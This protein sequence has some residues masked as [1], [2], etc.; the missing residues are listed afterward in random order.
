MPLL[1]IKKR[2]D[3]LLARRKSNNL[4]GRYLIFQKLKRQNNTT[5]ILFGFT[6]TKKVGIAVIRNKIKR[7]LRS[8]IRFL[9]KYEKNYF[10]NGYNYILIGKPRIKNAKFCEIK[11]EIICFLTRFKENEQ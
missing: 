3:F 7:R 8:I 10:D 6:V 1:T 11:K 2:K 9:I 5:P 4:S